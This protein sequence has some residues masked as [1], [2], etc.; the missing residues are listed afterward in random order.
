MSTERSTRCARPSEKK[1]AVPHEIFFG[2]MIWASI[3][4]SVRVVEVLDADNR[5]TVLLPLRRL[6]WVA[7]D[8]IEKVSHPPQCPSFWEIAVHYLQTTSTR[9]FRGTH[10][11]GL[12]PC[13]SCGSLPFS[14]NSITL[15]SSNTAVSRSAIA[16]VANS[17]GSA[18]TSPSS[19]ESSF[20]HFKPS[21]L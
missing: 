15:F 20:N 21:M 18:S 17:S 7:V 3:K 6:K 12:L 11:S 14:S 19:T 5:A 1:C 13:A 10:S 16:S 9:Q 2:N 8:Q 4:C